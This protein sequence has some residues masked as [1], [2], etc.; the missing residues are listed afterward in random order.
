MSSNLPVSSVGSSVLDA[1]SPL[2]NPIASPSLL[3]SHSTTTEQSI[4]FI[5][6][7]I[8]DIDRLIA[9][10]KTTV[11]RIDATQDGVEKITSV[12]AQQQN[13]DSIHI[14]SH[15]QAGNVQ[16]GNTHLSSETLT[17]YANHLQQWG[18]SL[19]AEGDLLF[20][21][22]NVAAGAGKSFIQQVSDLTGADVQASDDL[23]GNAALGGDWDL[24][25]ATGAI[26][27]AQ[28]IDPETQANYEGVLASRNGKQYFLTGKLTWAQAQA[29]ARR[30]GGNLVTISSK[31]EEKFLK[32]TFGTKEKFWTGLSDRRK[33]GQFTWVAG[34]AATYRNWQGGQQPANGRQ[35][36]TVIN[37]G[38]RRQWDDQR[39]NA[40]FRGIVELPET[41]SFNGSR[42][43]LTSGAGTYT[44]AYLEA[45]RLGGKLVTFEDG[46]E[47]TWLKQNFGNG[48]FWTGEPGRQPSS[49]SRLR[50]LI[51]L[52]GLGEPPVNQ[53]QTEE[54]IEGGPSS[55]ELERNSF[56]DINETDGT[57][58]FAVVR[59]G[60]TAKPG[61]ATVEVRGTGSS[62]AN[63]GE[64]YIGGTI[65]VNFARGE[66]RKVVSIPLINDNR[67]E[68]TETFKVSMQSVSGEEVRLGTVRTANVTLLDDESNTLDVTVRPVAENAGNVS[69]RLTRS[70]TRNA[71]SVN[72]STSDGTAIAGSDYTAVS[73]L[74]RF[75]A[76]ESSK[77]IL[78]PILDDTT[79]EENETFNLNFTNP[80][81]VTVERSVIPVTIT[82][83]D[84]VGFTR[85][86]LISGLVVPTS[87]DFTPNGDRTYILE[88]SGVIKTVA[89]TTGTPTVFADLSRQV[90]D[91]EDRGGL[92]IAVH[93]RFYSGS[94]YIYVSYTYDPPE[95]YQNLFPNS[96]LDGPDRLGNRPARVSRLTADPATGAFTGE[97]VVILGKNST[98]A[99]ISNPDKDSTQELDLP[100]SGRTPGGG[101]VQDY[102]KTDSQTHTIGQVR[103]SPDGQ[104]LYVSIGDGASYRLDPRAASTLNIDSL[105]GKMLRIDPLTGEGI[106]GNPYFNGDPNSNRS[107]VWQSGLRNSF[108][109]GF[110]PGDND[111]IFLGDVGW[112]NWE[113]VNVGGR[114]AN[115]GWPA[116]EGPEV[117]DEYS[118]FP[119][120][121]AFLRSGQPVT[122]PIRARSHAEGARAV[123]LG[124]FYNGRLYVTDVNEGTI[125]ALTIN[126]QN[127]VTSVQRIM[128]GM[129]YIVQ[130]KARPD[131]L[132]FVDLINGQI[133]RFR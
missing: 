69:V 101:F 6:S 40:K 109:F 53:P 79:G 120:V 99:N 24:E 82:D 126:A 111:N 124:D 58:E 1:T 129:P 72:F 104:Y 56:D 70:N 27:A 95:V 25:V 68:G 60:N 10:I 97:E 132:Y 91:V 125:D 85:D 67:K 61:A 98:W 18:K 100:E 94:P 78:V 11:V 118:I 20:Y 63:S 17:Q 87:F 16:L 41:L 7:T 8:A 73:Q 89:G 113:E 86:T 90:S 64:D 52:P 122:Q 114:G 48:K 88:K 29:E 23:T 75:N 49:G 12:L 39:G 26:E 133:G 127:Q 83:N 65:A 71:A 21:G 30:L 31:G 102:V 19:S 115:F 37:S 32:R 2:H 45:E 107:K 130:M 22:C 54:P 96:E 3:P 9:G 84:A 55:I 57:F 108:R 34:D 50:G 62:P 77:T 103:F 43:R 92:S 36:F 42:Y 46:T 116:Y 131:G 15:G 76:G 80:S 38:R 66:T 81:G 106:A 47:E 59:I 5:D 35:D 13:L 128:S 121:Q 123:M 105:S 110:K 4:V 33:E 117:Q 28:A 44:Q 93:P 51:E 112:N 119:E 74:V 14:I